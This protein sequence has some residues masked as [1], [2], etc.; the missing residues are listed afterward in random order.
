MAR[1]SI[2][3]TPT[4]ETTSP[5]A[6]PTTPTVEELLDTPTTTPT[7]TPRTP[8]ILKVP[9]TPKKEVPTCTVCGEP[10]HNGEAQVGFPQGTQGLAH[11]DCVVTVERKAGGF[12]A[13]Y[14]NFPLGGEPLLDP[15]RKNLTAYGRKI[16]QSAER[17][18]SSSAN[19]SLPAQSGRKSSISGVAKPT[20]KKAAAPVAPA[21]ITPSKA[22]TNPVRPTTPAMAG[23][24]EVCGK[25]FNQNTPT[26]LAPNG[27]RMHIHHK[28]AGSSTAPTTA[29]S[30]RPCRWCVN[31]G[32]KSPNTNTF[33]TVGTR[34]DEASS[35]RRQVMVNTYLCLEHLNTIVWNTTPRFVGKA[36]DDYTP[37]MANKPAVAPKIS[38]A[39]K[40][41]AAAPTPTPTAKK[42][43][44]G[45]KAAAPVVGVSFAEKMRLAREAKAA[46]R[47]DDARAEEI[48]TTAVQ[49]IEAEQAPVAPPSKAKRTRKNS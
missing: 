5:V 15:K 41:A 6:A 22:P 24:C 35:S 23:T 39:P 3:T 29:K 10:V 2:S 13:P 21:P 26:T 28:A 30:N 42:G 48:E 34:T 46:E 4:I 33:F 7:A 32:R 9:P 1:K 47:A 43:G 14:I 36:P 25:D 12:A 18:A 19:A 16:L 11:N 38:V 44:K 17:V 31:E 20:S 45:K 37:T 49:M 27:G 8:R 40:K